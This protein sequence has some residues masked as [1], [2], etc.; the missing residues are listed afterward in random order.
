MT[1]ERSAVLDRVKADLATEPDAFDRLRE[2]RERK[3]ERRRITAGVLGVGVTAVI[4]TGLL[5]SLGGEPG[6][7]EKVA[8]NGW[9]DVPAAPG[10]GEYFYVRFSWPGNGT[11]QAWIAADGSGHRVW[12]RGSGPDEDE[13]FSAQEGQQYLVPDLST[14]PSEF[15]DQLIQRSGSGGSSPVPIATTSPG[16][17]Q[18]TTSVLRAMSDLLTFDHV[19]MP[20]QVQALFGAAEQVDGVTKQSGVVDPWG[21]PAVSLT[22]VI[23]Y[24]PGP[25]ADLVWYFDPETGQ[26][27]GEAWF[28][29]GSG[30]PQS[31]T[32]VELSG[33]VG[34]DHEVPSAD[35]AFIPVA[36]D[37]T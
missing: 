36:S 8:D 27:L 19:L 31:A 9:A 35:E 23:D 22:H 4:V 37:K 32:I 17:S 7:G 12:Q 21:R 5:I 10:P 15:L 16:R 18:E 24:P 3:V 1:R 29:Q 25:A 33:I 20:G 14:D 34:S 26:F 28:K 2:R 30:N 13:R 6:T 11:V